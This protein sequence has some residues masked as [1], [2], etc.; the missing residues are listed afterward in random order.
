MPARRWGK[1]PRFCRLGPPLPPSFSGKSLICKDKKVVSRA[2]HASPL[3]HWR[4]LGLMREV[5]FGAAT[6]GGPEKTT[7]TPKK[8]GARYARDGSRDAIENRKQ[9]V[10]FQAS[11]FRNLEP[12]T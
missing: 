6:R 8:T 1:K 12:E 4:V 3:S 10:R 7:R 9:G 2:S 11:G 5:C